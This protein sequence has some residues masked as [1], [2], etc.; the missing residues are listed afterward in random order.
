MKS[1]QVVGRRVEILSS[2]CTGCMSNDEG[3][4][5]DC[6]VDELASWGDRSFVDVS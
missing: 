3:C 5:G 6:R 4:L 1:L 2:G